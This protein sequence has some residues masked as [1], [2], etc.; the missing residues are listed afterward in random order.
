MPHHAVLK[1]SNNEEID[2]ESIESVF[3]TIPEGIDERLRN[4][5]RYLDIEPRNPPSYQNVAP[6][7]IP[8]MI[9]SR[10]KTIENKIL[11]FE[12][13]RSL[14]TTTSESTNSPYI[15]S[16][17]RRIMTPGESA[18]A[19]TATVVQ[20]VINEYPDSGEPV[21]KVKRGPGRPRKNPPKI[22]AVTTN[23]NISSISTS[24]QMPPL[25]SNNIVPS[26]NVSLNPSINSD[27][28]PLSSSA[29]T[30]NPGTSPGQVSNLPQPET[31]T[32]TTLKPAVQ[33]SE[34][35]LQFF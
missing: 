33:V 9:Y 34:Q 14:P 1:N 17:G 18:A 22:P 32:T 2:I 12:E 13:E 19:Q 11:A 31:E 4:V 7:S 3:H 26:V 15:S 10:L 30:L 28:S 20:S 25:N 27:S 16:R 6:P 24:S 29:S 21:I 8:Q 23:V 5:E 35:F